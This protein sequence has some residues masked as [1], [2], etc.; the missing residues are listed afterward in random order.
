MILKTVVVNVLNYI[1]ATLHGNDHTDTPSKCAGFKNYQRLQ[2]KPYKEF[3]ID[4]VQRNL[5][6]LIPLQPYDR[7]TVE[8][9]FRLL[10]LIFYQAQQGGCS[11]R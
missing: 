8:G 2:R 5:T 1:I 10:H 3:S 6:L 4:F 7:S 11:W 9:P